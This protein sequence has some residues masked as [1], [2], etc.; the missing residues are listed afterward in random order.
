MVN[1]IATKPLTYK[2][3]RLQ[4]DDLFEARP[5]DARILIAIGKARDAGLSANP[6]PKATAQAHSTGT[7]DIKALRAEYAA[8]AGKK[9]FNGWKADD[10]RAKIA[11]ARKA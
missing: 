8:V 5:R 9:A 3:R 6:A 7:V 11:E 2:T 1:L 4:A 10:L